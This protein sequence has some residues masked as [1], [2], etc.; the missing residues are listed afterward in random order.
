MRYFSSSVRLHGPRVSLKFEVALLS[1]SITKQSSFRKIYGRA[2]ASVERTGDLH[3]PV[4]FIFHFNHQKKSRS[5]F[6]R[7][8]L[9]KDTLMC[10][11]R[12]IYM[13][14]KDSGA[15]VVENTNPNVHDSYDY[16]NN[17]HHEIPANV[18]RSRRGDFHV[19]TSPNGSC[20]K[21]LLLVL[22]HRLNGKYL[23]FVLTR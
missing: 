12:D 8:Q 21:A 9:I 17:N 23:F 16:N 7:P 19:K 14:V 6:S 11:I 10:L 1:P 3:A 15:E 20:C 22:R 5:I 13:V 18:C 4:I 2:N